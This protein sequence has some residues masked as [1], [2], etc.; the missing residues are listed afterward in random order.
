MLRPLYLSEDYK[1]LKS[2]IYIS[3]L[4]FEE[5]KNVIYV[6]SLCIIF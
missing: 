1:L 6:F 5:V 4:K 3:N 2:V